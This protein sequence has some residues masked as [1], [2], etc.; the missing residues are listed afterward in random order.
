MAKKLKKHTNIADFENSGFGTYNEDLGGGTPVGGVWGGR[1]GRV[2]W[3]NRKNAGEVS[4]GASRDEQPRTADGKFSYNS[5]NGKETKYTPR[6]KTVNPLL[7]GGK[8]GIKI[9]TVKAQF[10]ERKGEFY[11]K[12]KSVFYQAS[13]GLAT[14]VGK[15]YLIKVAG[16]DIW[17]IARRSWDISTGQFGGENTAFTKTKRGRVSAQDKA[18]KR[19]A[20]K[21][22]Q[23]QFVMDK[24]DPNAIR[25]AKLKIKG[26][27]DSSLKQASSNLIQQASSNNSQN[28]S[29]NTNSEGIKNPDRKIDGKSDASQMKHTVVEIA[30]IREILKDQGFDSTGITDEQIDQMADQYFDFN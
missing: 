12:Y 21:T 10:Q 16:E 26:S 30:A 24:K 5:L 19:F 25:A 22:G 20:K 28:Q 17:E 29:Q 4:Q 15:D 3:Q 14:K 18:A 1:S 7:T 13:S 8:N 9:S 27:N 2:G 23:E 11:D 6:G